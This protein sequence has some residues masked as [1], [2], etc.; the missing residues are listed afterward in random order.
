M[1]EIV[2]ILSKT[3]RGLA[4]AVLASA[5]LAGCVMGGGS[6]P[7]GVFNG[8]GTDHMAMIVL[9][10]SDYNPKTGQN[11]PTWAQYQA[12]QEAASAVGIQVDWQL[13]SGFEAAGSEAMPYLGAGAVGGASQ[14]IAYAGAD[15]GA[16]ATVSGITY[17]MGGAV[18]GLVTASYAN[19][20]AVAKLLEDT[21]RDRENDGQSIFHNVHVAAAY[22]RSRNNT[23]SPA[24]ELARHMPDFSGPATNPNQ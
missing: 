11:A 20:S 8:L 14:G 7:P 9:A 2:M 17:M 15:A 23:D 22:I 13:S 3:L 18:N 21:I 19:V 16:A 12:V 4:F 24:P 1:M 5:M 6:T 10:R